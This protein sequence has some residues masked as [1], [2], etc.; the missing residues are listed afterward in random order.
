MGV[1]FM[2]K[3]T[4]T[5]SLVHLFH[6]LSRRY[7]QKAWNTPKE[8]SCFLCIDICNGFDSK[9]DSPHYASLKHLDLYYLPAI[10]SIAF[11]EPNHNLTKSVGN[12]AAPPL[13]FHFPDDGGSERGATLKRRSLHSA[14]R[15]E[16]KSEDRGATF[17]GVVIRAAAVKLGPLS[18][19]LAPSIYLAEAS[20]LPSS[21]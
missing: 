17:Y 12:Q 10:E 18:L 7:S 3:I 20:F 4:S 11:S 6:S 5:S 21:L 13:H 1:C 14:A 19:S 8:K 15:S 16:L 2:S 9:A